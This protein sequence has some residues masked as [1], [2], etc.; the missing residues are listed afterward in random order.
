MTKPDAAELW[1]LIGI[2]KFGV[3]YILD[4]HDWF[5]DA[6]VIEAGMDSEEAG[7]LVPKGTATGTAHLMT[8][9]KITGGGPDYNGEYWGPEISGDWE[10]VIQELRP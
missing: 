4:A 3:A 1:L 6:P 8:N 10:Q 2:D 7:V 5:Y 9:V